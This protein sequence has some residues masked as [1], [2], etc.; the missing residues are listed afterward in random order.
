MTDQ[1][2]QLSVQWWQWS[3]QWRRDHTDQSMVATDGRTMVA[4]DGLINGGNGAIIQ[5]DHTEQSYSV[6]SRSDHTEQ[7][8]ANQWRQLSVQWR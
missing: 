6:G 3:K 7:S 1:W 4:I 2:Q 8:M 5:S